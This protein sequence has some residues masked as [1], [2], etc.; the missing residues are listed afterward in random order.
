[1]NRKHFVLLGW[2]TISTCSAYT[3][4]QQPSAA[5]KQAKSSTTAAAQ[6]TPTKP[7]T[8]SRLFW[9]DSASDTIRWANVQKGDSWEAK[10]ADIA[11]FPKLDGEQVDFV[12]MEEI[13]GVLLSGVHD[14]EDGA[15]QSG[16]IAIDG[17]V[18]KEA[19]GD[20]F[21]WQFKRAPSLKKAKL[22]KEQGNP[23]HV[24]TYDNRFY[25]AN[26]KKNGFTMVDAAALAGGKAADRFFEGGGGH[27]T[28]AAVD[29]KVCYA[30]WI[31]REGDNKGRV[32]VVPLTSGAGAAYSFH[33]P[34][35]GIHGATA[36]AGKVFF[37]PSDG[38]CWVPADLNLAKTNAAESI[39]HVSLGK[40]SDDKPLRT[41]AFAN[42]L[43]WVLCTTGTGPEA[44]LCMLDAQSAKPTVIK[45][46][47]GLEEG[48]TITTPTPVKAPNGKHYALLF[49]ESKQG[50][51][52]EKL[53]AVQLDANAD[54]QLGDMAIGTTLE[55]GASQIDGHSGHHELTV[56]PSRRLAFFT[57][58]GDGSIWVLSL[59]D[60]SI[61]AKLQVS[62]TPTRIVA[63]GG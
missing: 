49:Q 58:P 13:D 18:D 5:S 30:T 53:I 28:L 27:I 10:P 8:V 47:L 42:H 3:S 31:D 39:V 36:N 15:A 45:F 24:Y 46:S 20:H 4:A 25:L 62:G 11:G 26:D 43:N 7:R 48:M 51:G 32:D 37:A 50:S 1:M 44:S 35:G 34:S 33:L 63:I 22:D 55:V 52:K 41:G 59:T 40:T 14:H 9:Q 57:N 12:Q 6:N 19:H 38:I 2:L 61:Q 17:G 54:G 56:T 60:M 23:A 21:H 16:W 29:N